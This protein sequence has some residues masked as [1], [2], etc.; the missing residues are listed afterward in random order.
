MEDDFNAEELR[1]GFYRADA[2]LTLGPAVMVGIAVG[3]L[4]L[5]GLCFWLGYWMGGRGV[6]NAPVVVQQAAAPAAPKKSSQREAADV[7]LPATEAAGASAPGDTQPRS[8]FGANSAPPAV[9]PALPDR[10]T[11][12]APAL[13]LMVQIAA[14]SQQEDADVLVAALRRR[15]YAVLVRRD[16]ADSKFHV[17]VGPFT[18]RGDADTMRQKLVNDG[19]NAIVEP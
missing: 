3:L 19:Y 13:A 10:E 11:A 2:E 5:C 14:V 17:Q 7:S 6:H 9:K 4:S 15:G 18:N 1:P 8:S 12:P 16:R